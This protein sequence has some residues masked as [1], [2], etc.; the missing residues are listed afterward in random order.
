MYYLCNTGSSEG[1]YDGHHIDSKLKLQEF[2]DAVID[3]PPPHDCLHNAAE[4]IISQDNIWGL[5]RY[6]S[7]SYAL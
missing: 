2:W 4:I 6:I 7:S 5:F 1:H 3:I